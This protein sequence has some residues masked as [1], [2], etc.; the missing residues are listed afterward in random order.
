MYVHAYM[1]NFHVDLCCRYVRV[2]VYT[3]GLRTVHTY[4]R[5]YM[6]TTYSDGCQQSHCT[7]KYSQLPLENTQTRHTGSP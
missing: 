4:V 7:C 6:N 5:T 1:Y 2:Y 3:M